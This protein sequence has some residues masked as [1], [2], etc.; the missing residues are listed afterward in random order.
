LKAA[1]P[2]LPFRKAPAR[3]SPGTR[4]KATKNS[5]IQRAARENI[6]AD[7]RLRLVYPPDNLFKSR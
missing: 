6:R 2:A 1:S 7:P 4:T 5:L 3:P